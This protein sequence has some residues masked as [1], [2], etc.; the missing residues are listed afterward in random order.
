MPDIRSEIHDLV[1]TMRRQFTP[2]SYWPGCEVKNVDDKDEYTTDNGYI[3]AIVGKHNQQR[4]R[5]YGEPVDI[6]VGDF[7]DV[8]YFPGYS[9]YRVFGGTK[10][11]TA[12][13]GGIDVTRVSKIYKPD[14]SGTALYSDAGGT[15]RIPLDLVVSGKAAIGTTDL[16]AVLDIDQPSNVAAIPVIKVDQADIGHVSILFSAN[17]VDNDIR[18][19]EVD[20]T[21]APALDWDE[22]EDAWGWNK[23]H[24]VTAGNVI[25][26]NLMQADDIICDTNMYI[27]ESANSKQVI[28]ATFN[29]GGQDDEILSF[30]SSDVAHGMTG[31]T[32]T[33]TYGHFLKTSATAGGLGIRGFSEGNAG[34]LITGV[35]S[36]ADTAKSTSA[37]GAMMFQGS[38]KSGTGFSS[39]GTNENVF[40]VRNHG[41]AAFLI[42]AEGDIHYDGTN[43][44]GAWDSYDDT[45]VLRALSLEV[46]DP[47]TI[48]K[49]EFDEFIRYNKQH[50][51]DMGV[52]SDGGFINLT[53][54]VRLTTGALWQQ[55]LKIQELEARLNGKL[56]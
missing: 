11:G 55:N 49:T 21:G 50:L 10:G 51:I 3:E 27:N 35:G 25:I 38:K 28:G 9:V 53:Q 22:S 42:T 29:Q 44:P 23:G 18:I 33:D 4:V 40:V 15:I 20:V 7:V 30:K 24:R 39:L 8:E 2:P 14:L 31:A 48:I 6:S 56:N 16:D 13:V 5:Y 52:L 45:Q 36:T 32:E 34:C 17:G 26:S 37:Q 47:A 12:N 19:F 1:D 41:S 46:S 54:I 43:N